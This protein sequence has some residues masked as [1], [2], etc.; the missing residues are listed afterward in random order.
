EVGRRCTQ[1][2]SDAKWRRATQFRGAAEQEV[3]AEHL[4]MTFVVRVAA[5]QRHAPLLREVV[6]EVA[7]YRPRL[8][9]DVTAG[10]RG[11]PGECDAR[12]IK[13]HVEDIEGVR[14]EIIKAGDAL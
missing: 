14:V 10:G 9:I 5:A 3:R 12:R 7:E 1:L 2:S 11:K 6:G 13:A 4:R 8:R